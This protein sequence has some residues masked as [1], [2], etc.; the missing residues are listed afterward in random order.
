M[1]FWPNSLKLYQYT[2]QYYNVCPNLKLMSLMLNSCHILGYWISKQQIHCIARAF[3]FAFL[4]NTIWTFAW[5]WAHKTLK[6]IVDTWGYFCVIP[7]W[8]YG[9]RC[10]ARMWSTVKFLQKW[11][12]MRNF[13]QCFHAIYVDIW[14]ANSISKISSALSP[15]PSSSPSPPL[16]SS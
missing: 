14:I 15:P 13:L 6:H 8:W 4:Y 11:Y 1:G 10:S 9:G 2:S 3:L 5:T 12:P 7:A 16:S